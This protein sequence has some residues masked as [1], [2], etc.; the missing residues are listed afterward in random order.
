MNVIDIV[1][2]WLIKND[3]DGMYNDDFDTETPCG[4]GLDDLM[5]CSC[6]D[7]ACSPAYKREIHGE[8][9]YFQTKIEK[10]LKDAR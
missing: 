10:E 9:Y 2:E 5:P 8:I 3:Y 6:P 7:Q 4:C 1:K